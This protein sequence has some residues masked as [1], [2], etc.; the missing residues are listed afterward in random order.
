[1][2]N[3]PQRIIKTVLP[4]ARVDVGIDPYK[5]CTDSPGCIRI[6]GYAPPGGQGRPPLRVRSILHWCVCICNI[7]PPGGVEPRPYANVVISTDS[8]WCIPICVCTAQSFR[9]G[10]AVPPPFT[11][12][13]LWM[14]QAR[15]SARI[16]NRGLNEPFRPRIFFLIPARRRRLCGS[17]RAPA[18]RGGCRRS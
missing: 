10:F 3:L 2:A 17:G 9:H 11:Q 5:R 18:A 8:H 6:C 14:A 12:G 13:R 4:I 1:M 16:K 7:V 15:R